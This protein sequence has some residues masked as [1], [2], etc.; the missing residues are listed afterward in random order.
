MKKTLLIA[1][2]LLLILAGPAL[3]AK[4]GN[5]PPPDTALQDQVN[6]N[7]ANIQTNS[8][9]ITAEEAARQIEDTALQGQIDD[10]LNSN[11][12][13]A[14]AVMYMKS[15]LYTTIPNCPEYW[16][17]ANYASIT[18]APGIE[19]KERTCFYCAQ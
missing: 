11:T 4:G 13:T 8:A 16:A 6:E 9:A 18:I 1:V 10:I 7:T 15:K 5:K 17:E 12:G 19:F 2:S 14:P 3:A